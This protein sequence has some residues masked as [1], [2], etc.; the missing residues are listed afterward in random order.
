[1]ARKLARRPKAERLRDDGGE[2]PPN[3]ANEEHAAQALVQL[4]N[5]DPD[6]AR[7][8]N[9]A[10]FSKSDVNTGHAL[11]RRWEASGKLTGDE[12]A[13]AVD[14]AN[15]YRRQVGP[16]PEPKGKAKR[17]QS[18]TRTIDMGNNESLSMGVFED[19]DGTYYAMTFSQSKDGFKTRAGA[20]RWLARHIS[21]DSQPSGAS[22]DERLFVGVMPTGIVYA[23]RSREVDGDYARCAF[24]PF[25]TLAL[26]VSP[27]CPEEL[28]GPI[29]ADA[30]TI[31][32]RRGEK[33]AISASGQTVVLGSK[34][35]DVPA[36]PISTNT[37]SG[38]R[39]SNPLSYAGHSLATVQDIAAFLKLSLG[40]LYERYMLNINVVRNVGDNSVMLTFYRVHPGADELEAANAKCKVRL[41]IHGAGRTNASTWPDDAT[42]SELTAFTVW[43]HNAPKFRKRTGPPSV[44]VAAV[45]SWFVLNIAE[46][47]GTS[48]PAQTGRL[49]DVR[50]DDMDAQV[51]REE[52]AMGNALRAERDREEAEWSDA[53]RRGVKAEIANGHD[54][55]T[56]KR[57][58]V[59]NLGKDFEHYTKRD[60]EKWGER[61]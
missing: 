41:N 3:D 19:T 51:A 52:A 43:A 34:Y 48:D 44:I 33:F 16:L 5:M 58:A 11:A 46:L 17:Q 26:D 4:A 23:D 30:A 55:E 40:K 27:K 18:E 29:R 8:V 2:R 20:E 54:A 61:P 13:W 59:A 15:K 12:W 56:A 35:A 25:D 50:I 7:Q 45:S 60:E 42:P 39:G 36:A 22:A 24:L 9:D 47:T 14:V 6:K 38:K 37:T 53:V 1:M 57:I 49:R 32:A 10:G 28:R 31:I 21:Q